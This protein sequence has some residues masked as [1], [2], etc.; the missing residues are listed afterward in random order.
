MNIDIIGAA[1]NLGANRLGVEKGFRTLNEKLDLKQ[2][3]SDHVVEVVGEVVSPSFDEL[4]F[5]DTL[6]KNKRSI[7]DFNTRLADQVSASI[8]R[9]NM[10]L[11]VGGDHALAW[12]SISGVA[13]NYDNLGCIYIDAHGDFNPAELSPSHNVHGMHMAYLMGMVDSEDVNF[14]QFGVKLN[15]DNVYFVG[16]R[17]LDYGEKDLAKQYDLNI[18]TSDDIRTLGI[19]K[20][21]ADLLKKI[22]NSTLKH[23]HLS[24]DID[25]ID[26]S[27]CPGTGVPEVNGITIKDVEYLL[28]KILATGKIVSI[29]FV[30]FNPLLDKKDKTLILCG[31]L[32]KQINLNWK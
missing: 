15:K 10:P 11:V 6:M 21:A 30:E 5:E 23:Y 8:K 14:Y 4:Q 27:L 12:G 19:S 7:F 16:T 29:D 20:I 25:V 24:L 17:S 13:D 1:L 2:I 32:L 9:G 18:Q 22:E 26:P 3:F 31:D 28:E